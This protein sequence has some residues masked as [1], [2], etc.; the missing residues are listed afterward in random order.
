[1]TL[2]KASNARPTGI[3]AIIRERLGTNGQ[4]RGMKTRSSVKR[5]CDGCKVW[6]FRPVFPFY[7]FWGGATKL[8]GKHLS[9]VLTTSSSLS[10]PSEER[11]AFTLYGKFILL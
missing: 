7:F 5:L 10:S 2:V 6:V 1:M 11:I 8:F 4:I 3:D 9:S